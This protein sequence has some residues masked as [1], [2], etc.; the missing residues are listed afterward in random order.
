MGL[1]QLCKF[2]HMKSTVNVHLFCLREVV[3]V[4]LHHL[5]L[6][7]L[8]C[9]DSALPLHLQKWAHDC[10][11]NAKGNLVK[12]GWGGLMCEHGLTHSRIWYTTQYKTSEVLNI[13]QQ[14]RRCGQQK[15]PS[16]E[17]L[18]PSIW[19]GTAS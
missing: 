2:L 1:N 8:C 10:M 13:L 19:M 3:L 11:G 7:S 4:G 9:T 14:Q 17:S 18:P 6:S 12:T 15:L 16:T 5:F